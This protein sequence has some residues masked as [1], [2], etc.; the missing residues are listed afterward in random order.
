[1]VLNL[2]GGTEPCKL[3]QCIHRTLR[4]W[5]NKYDFFKTGIYFISAQ[6]VPCIRCTQNHCVQR[7][8]PTKHEFKKMVLLKIVLEFLTSAKPLRLTQRT[9]GVKNH[10][11]NVN[12]TVCLLN[13]F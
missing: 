4:N 1:M 2:I 12:L 8:K 5:K 13:K 6:N 11:S 7:T 3:H 9:P 10:W